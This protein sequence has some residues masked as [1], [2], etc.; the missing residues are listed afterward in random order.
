MKPSPLTRGVTICC[1]DQSEVPAWR[2]PASDRARAAAFGF[3]HDRAVGDVGD[4]VAAFGG[5][6]QAAFVAQR[7]PEP[8]FSGGETISHAR[9]SGSTPSALGSVVMLP[10]VS[11][12][13]AWPCSFLATI[14]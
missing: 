7:S 8:S 2:L 5:L 14:R 6:D 4:R 1:E 12:P 10:N 3:R 11:A 9:P 13:S